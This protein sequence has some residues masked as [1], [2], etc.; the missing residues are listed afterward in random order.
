MKNILIDTDVLLDFFLER[1]PF[2][3][4]AESLISLCEKRQLNG[5]ITP[6]ICSNLY[7][8]LRKAKSHEFVGEKIALFLS[9]IDVLIID[10]AIISEALNS[11]FS[12]FEDALQ[13]YAAENSTIIDAIIT[14]NVK[15]Y[16]HS[17][18]SIFTPEDFLKILN[19]I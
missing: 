1:Q 19:T 8:M 9:Y 13:N 10:K 2:V 4:N 16:R 6:V 17:K 3:E 15:D 18:I 14:R 7:Y 11:A 12:D 5:Y